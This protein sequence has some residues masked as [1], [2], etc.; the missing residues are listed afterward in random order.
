MRVSLR[1]FMRGLLCALAGFQVGAALADDWLPVTPDDL[2]MTSVPQ[3]PGV[4]AVILYRQVDRDDSNDRED[5]Y[6][7]IKILSDE[8]RSYADVEIPYRDYHESVR[9]I[10]ARTIRPDGSIVP[11]TGTVYEKP[12]VRSRAGALLAKTFQLPA[13]EP[14]CI[15]EYRYR[16]Q[17]AYGWTYNSQ[18][19][20]SGNLFTREVKFSLVPNRTLSLRW[21]WPNGLPPGTAKPH[22]EKDR[23]LLEAHDVPAFVTEDHMPPENELK[24]RVD[25]IYT[26]G[27]IETAP[28]AFWRTYGIN[29][30]KG[31]QDFTDQRTAMERAV[32]QIVQP[33]DSDE[34]KLR[35]IYARMQ[36][37]RNLSYERPRTAQETE[38][39]DARKIYNVATVWNLDAGHEAEINW[40]FLALARAAGVAADPV[41]ISQ[42][43]EYIFDPR[44]MNPGQLDTSVVL[45]SLGGKDVYLDPGTPFTPF[46]MQPWDRTDAR[47]L[48]LNADGGVWVVTPLPDASAS[49]TERRAVLRLAAG[50][51]EGKL[52]VRYTGLEASWRRLQ[53]RNED[54]TGRR[55]FLEKQI[56]SMVP[57]GIDIK[58]TNN[59]DWSASDA[60]LVAEF[61]FRVPGWATSAGHRELLPIGLFGGAERHTFEHATRIQPLYFEFPR[62]YLDDVAI[63]LPAGWHVDSVPP[64]HT[65]DLK[66]LLYKS[67]TQNAQQSLRLTRELT[68]TFYEATAQSYEPVQAFF[69]KVR[70]GDE[71]QAVI[72]PAASAAR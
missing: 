53:E 30:W 54:D 42:R 23:V 13:A 60:P 68:I 62:Q 19:I 5:V 64:P 40:L 44:L 61:D 6:M 46:G 2:H 34:E 71:E 15:V 70:T 45:V 16:H 56:E 43:S 55:Q 38:R 26:R 8:G 52:T 48:R 29:L 21:S 10:E 72:A 63:E 22:L 12:M 31:T 69:E 3:A 28:A 20:L 58:L 1:I 57:V 11:F 39:E 4:A 33:G 7:R 32:S 9:D 67:A 14:G 65:T 18:W 41:Q 51:L 50:A 36:R 27:R 59:P 17:Y 47:G 25:F 37:V 66:V 35:K 49:R 24:S